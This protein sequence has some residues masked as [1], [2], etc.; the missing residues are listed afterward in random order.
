MITSVSPCP[1]VY[2]LAACTDSEKI[3]APKASFFLF[4]S[5]KI[6]GTKWHN[7]FLGESIQVHSGSVSYVLALG[8]FA[9]PTS[10][11]AKTQS[12]AGGGNPGLNGGLAS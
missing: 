5:L 12:N 2:D 7:T 10:Q 11:D 6:L 3:L 4:L 8:N 1:S 9:E